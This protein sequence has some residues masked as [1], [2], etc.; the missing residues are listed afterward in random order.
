M[1]FQCDKIFYTD[2]NVPSIEALSVYPSG[3]KS[4]SRPVNL[5]D[6][7]A[8][9]T[10]S[11]TNTGDRARAE[12]P[13]LY[14]SYPESAKQPVRQLQGFE[15]VELARRERSTVTFP[16]RRQ[17]VSFWDV[18]AEQ[19][20]VKEGEYKFSAGASSRDLRLSRTVTIRTDRCLVLA[21]VRVI[22]NSLIV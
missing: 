7:I 15:R 13:Q 5:W 14:L 11:V 19:W 2:L 20:A 9:V 8:N 1:V 22:N 21:V 4:V 17:D 6:V 3:K 16:I 12:I 10:V 18:E